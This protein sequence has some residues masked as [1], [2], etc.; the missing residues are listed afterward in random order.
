MSVHDSEL[1]RGVKPEETETER[2]KKEGDG[3]KAG[4]AW[5]GRKDGDP[6]GWV[7]CGGVGVVKM[8]WKSLY[9]P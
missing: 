8:W 3:R 1:A 4:D 2:R 7:D 5:E 9:F 6:G